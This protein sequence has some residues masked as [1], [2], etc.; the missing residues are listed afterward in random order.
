MATT[1]IITIHDVL[2][3]VGFTALL[4][5]EVDASYVAALLTILGFS[6][7]DSVVIFDPHP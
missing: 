1:G 6:I 7:N 2:V 3:M 5:I 4:E